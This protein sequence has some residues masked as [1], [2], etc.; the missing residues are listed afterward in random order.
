MEEVNKSNNNFPIV[1]EKMTFNVFSYYI[2]TKKSK[3]S[4]GYLSDT[5]YGGVL[6]SLTH[7]YRMS[8]KTTD[9]TDLSRRSG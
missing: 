3:N 7:L 5:S 6:I 4:G 1:L 2:S 9:D 8:G